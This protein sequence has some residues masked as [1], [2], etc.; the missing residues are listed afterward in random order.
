LC[1]RHRQGT[2]IELGK[3]LHHSDA[4]SEYTSIRFTEHLELE[5]IAPSIGTVG[6]AYDNAPDGI[7]HRFC[8][9]PN[10][11]PRP[12]STTAPTGPPADVEHATAGWVDWYDHRRL[13]GSLGMTTPVEYEQ[14][15]DASRQPVESI[16]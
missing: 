14:A 10:A 12:S 3:L 4:G 13:H 16:T 8:S 2:P 6:D 9:R 5:E 11:S 7:D 1:D 15:H